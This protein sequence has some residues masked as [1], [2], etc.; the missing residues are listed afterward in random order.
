MR[1]TSTS[2]ER[3]CGTSLS[4]PPQRKYHSVP[5]KLIV[6]SPQP[7]SG[8]VFS[9]CNCTIW[10]SANQPAST[11]SSI[12]PIP[13]ACW[14]EACISAIPA[15]ANTTR[16]TM[17]SSNVIP[18]CPLH[19]ETSPSKRVIKPFSST[20]SP[21]TASSPTCLKRSL[22]GVTSPPGSSKISGSAPSS[23]SDIHCKPLRYCSSRRT[24][25]GSLP[26]MAARRGCQVCQTYPCQISPPSANVGGLSA[27]PRCRTLNFHPSN[28]T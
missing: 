22:N 21:T 5:A 25:S 4:G 12:R 2:K 9:S 20:C 7:F 19:N 3:G 27:V 1:R 11:F 28:R 6:F 18:S 23:C 24:S 16:A 8:Q 13:A 14:V 17:T 10:L 26:P 15:S